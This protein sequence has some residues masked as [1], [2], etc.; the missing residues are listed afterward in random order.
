MFNK[1]IPFNNLPILPWNFDFNKV[2][3]LKLA[4]KATWKL[5]KLNWLIYLVPNKNI[6]ISPLIINESVKSSEIENIH[7]TTQKVLQAKVLPNEFLSWAEKEVLH[8]HDAILT[9]FDN[10][11]KNG[12]ISVNSILEIQSIIKENNSWIRKISGTVIWNWFWDI[13]YSPPS[14][15][16]NINNLLKNL[17]IFINNFE[18]DIDALIKMPVIHYQF[19]AIHPFYDWNWRTW[20]I[21]NILYLILAKKLDFPVLFLSEYINNSRNKYYSL[22]NE[23]HKTWDYSEFIIYILEWV[24]FQSDKTSKKI[25]EI[26]NLMEKTQEEIKK[27]NLDYFKITEILFSTPFITVSEF[28]KKLEVARTTSTRI[29]KKL[30]ENNIILSEKIWVNKLI[31]LKDFIKLLKD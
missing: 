20:R 14:W 21:I 26:K 16:E 8:Y 7:T 5:E 10:L 13:I 25:L 30:E 3:F 29:I 19:E 24:I 6:L 31:F 15:E 4:I 28:T 2:D 17:E 23:I 9:W 1:D 18:D 22:L 12:F 27:L 11:K